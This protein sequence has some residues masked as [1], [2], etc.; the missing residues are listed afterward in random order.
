[1]Q[2][3]RQ[4]LRIE[5]AH[6]LAVERTACSTAIAQTLDASHQPLGNEGGG[7]LCP[8]IRFPD[9]RTFY[10][11]WRLG[12]AEPAPALAA[13]LAADT[14]RLAALYILCRFHA[15]PVPRP[16]TLPD[17]ILS[18][19]LF[20]Y[21]SLYVVARS[22]R[23]L[24]PSTLSSC[25]PPL[26]GTRW[27]TP[28][29]PHTPASFY[30]PCPAWLVFL[31]EPPLSPLSAPFS[32]APLSYPRCCCAAHS[33]LLCIPARRPSLGRPPLAPPPGWLLRRA[34]PPPPHGAPHLWLAACRASRPTGQW[35]W[36]L[37]GGPGG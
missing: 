8:S 5:T 13:E 21:S 2:G 24:L 29:W 34:P 9:A 19:P 17:V 26:G 23:P 12:G 1:M 10:T 16:A 14:R 15:L 6:A 32:F 33:P 31:P 11:L 27:A 36:T 25:L 37:A 28:S 35:R 22:S 4:R 20:H 7:L 30:T 18:S 3:P